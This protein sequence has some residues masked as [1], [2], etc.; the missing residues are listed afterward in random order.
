MREYCLSR[1]DID[2]ITGGRGLKGVWALWLHRRAGRAVELSL[3]RARAGRA[4]WLPQGRA[5]AG[6]LGP[7]LG[8]VQQG[9]RLFREGR[10]GGG[11]GSVRLVNKASPNH[12]L[13]SRLPMPMCVCVAQT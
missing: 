2:F 5:R 12:P 9:G 10:E 6:R 8:G 1:E 3:G 4:V 11:R 7:G 13:H